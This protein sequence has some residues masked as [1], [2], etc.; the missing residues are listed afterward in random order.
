MIDIAAIKAGRI[1]VT[2]LSGFLGAGKTTL[3]NHMIQ[4]GQDSKI[5]VIVNDFGDINIDS[6]LIN[7]REDCELSLT[8]GCICCS[9][10]K[11]L[12]Q[13][14][15]GQLKLK[16]K[17]EHIIIECSGVSDPSQVLNTL[18]FPLLRFH[19]QVDGL[20][21]VI[22]CSGLLQLDEDYSRLARRQIEPANLLILNKVDLVDEQT[23]E[24]VRHFIRDVSPKAVILETTGCKIPLDLVLGF[25]ELPALADLG[26]LEELD[27]HIHK[28]GQAG[29]PAHGH[30][31]HD[32][33]FES[34]SFDCERPLAK[35]SLTHLM[36]DLDPDIVRVKGF[37][38]WDDPKNPLV[39]VNRVGQWVDFETYFQE[40]DVPQR[41]RLVF[42][43]KPGWKRHSDLEDRLLSC[44]S[45]I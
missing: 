9:I 31:E 32:L 28:A 23:L 11:D 1:R 3:L 14:V 5:A 22:D 36:E 20:F 8:G 21:T 29:K 10:Q 16:D 13:A 33:A 42:I 15:I 38:Y 4:A 41:T 30:G 45:E 37:V 25:K 6:E 40:K 26:A 24:Q 43:G 19:L 17:P 18:A 35:S 34:W 12:L 27:V 44:R 39:L 2:V 7:G